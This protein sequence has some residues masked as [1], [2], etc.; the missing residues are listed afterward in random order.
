MSSTE[1]RLQEQQSRCFQDPE[2]RP[3]VKMLVE[4]EEVLREEEARPP[5]EGRWRRSP[6]GGQ[7]AP[8]L[9]RERGLLA[10]STNG[11]LEVGTGI[12]I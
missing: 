5:A 8:H 7:G 6:E 1:G 9:P 2:R 4:V 10:G 11:P 12:Q 3:R